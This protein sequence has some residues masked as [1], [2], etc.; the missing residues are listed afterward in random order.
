MELHHS[1]TNIDDGDINVKIG[2]DDDDDNE[3]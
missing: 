3:D 2:N 1:N